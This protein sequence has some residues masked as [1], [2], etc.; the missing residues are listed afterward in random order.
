MRLNVL[1]HLFVIF[2][3]NSE[4]YEQKREEM[5]KDLMEQKKKKIEEYPSEMQNK[6][7]DAQRR[8]FANERGKETNKQKKRIKIR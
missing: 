1:K 8:L 3:K 5:K 4:N 2:K 7:Q 6:S